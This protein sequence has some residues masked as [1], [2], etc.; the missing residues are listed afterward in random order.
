MD[1]EIREII[2]SPDYEA[3][4]SELNDDIREKYDYV[5][6]IIKTIKV[7]SKKFVKHL[8]DTDLYEARMSVGNN[9]YRT[10]LFAIDKTSFIESS[11]V[12]FLNSFLKKSTK[13]YKKEIKKAYK[14]LDNYRRE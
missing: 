5:E 2:Y 3:Y 12:L 4:Y 13:D 7:V 1:I 10:I 11:K 14:I 6:H 8:E 9:E